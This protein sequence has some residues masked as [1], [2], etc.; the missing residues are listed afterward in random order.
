[1][2]IA[3]I[4]QFVKSLE[5]ERSKEGRVR[6]LEALSASGLRSVRYAKEIQGLTEIVANDISRDA[7]ETIKNNIKINEVQNKVTASHNGKYL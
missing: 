2:S 3:V 5:S 4:Q 6:C 1:M 7:V